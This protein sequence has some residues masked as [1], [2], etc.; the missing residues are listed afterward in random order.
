MGRHWWTTQLQLHL[1]LDIL[2]QYLPNSYAIH[3]Y[4]QLL[5]D[6]FGAHK[7]CHPRV[8]RDLACSQI[9][10]AAGYGGGEYRWL[11]LYEI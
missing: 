8:V 4:S 7:H 11:A 3:R 1:D 5:A 10:Q 2:V 9:E 6:M